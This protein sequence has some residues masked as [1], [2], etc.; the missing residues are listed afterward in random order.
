M[1]RSLARPV[2]VLGITA[3]LGVSGTATAAPAAHHQGRILTVA[4]GCSSGWT[5]ARIN[6]QHKCL[7]VGEF[8]AHS[9]NRQY[10]RYGFRC[11]H[12]DSSVDRYRLTRA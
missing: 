2:A 4:A 12:Y 11:T 1:F 6:G 10:R 9:A 5:S 7:R 3:A 8:C